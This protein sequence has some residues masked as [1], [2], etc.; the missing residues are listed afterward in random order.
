MRD[1][2]ITGEA[3]EK[4]KKDA[5][6]IYTHNP[7]WADEY[8]NAPSDNCRERLAISYVHSM[9]SDG[10]VDKEIVEKVENRLS[11]EDWV[12]LCHNTPPNPWRGKCMKN[13][14]RIGGKVVCPN[15][16]KLCRYCVADSKNKGNSY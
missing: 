12:Y 1:K 5:I 2:I 10:L 3:F 15:R 7:S 11:L 8:N 4:A 9:I 13:I 16:G 14:A 6:K